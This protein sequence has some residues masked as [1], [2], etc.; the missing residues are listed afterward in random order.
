MLKEYRGDLHIHSCLSPCGEKDMTPKNIIESAKN[1]G[2]NLI[3]ISDHN[4]CENVSAVLKMGEKL[5]IKVLGGVEITT[6]EE[7]HIL[8]FFDNIS[9]VLKIQEIIYQNLDGE[10]D[11]DLFGE[12]LIVNEDDK[13]VGENKKLL[14]SATKLKLNSVINLIQS[15]GGISIASH[16][17]RQTFSIISQ[18]GFIPED[19]K[20]DAVEVSPNYK[21]QTTAPKGH[22]KLQNLPIV[23]FSDAH[24]LEDIGKC[25]TTFFVDDVTINELKGALNYGRFIITYPGYS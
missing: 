22:P 17:D 1:R 13:V 5:G 20:L 16:I 15:Y 2:L 24:K 4:S 23:S 14:I 18:L 3:G 21:P 6:E 19:L 25:V 8:G 7:V 11:K 9:Q 10:N 12:Q